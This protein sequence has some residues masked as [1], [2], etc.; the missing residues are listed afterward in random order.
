MY[1][2]PE[3]TLHF[4]T[5]INLLLKQDNLKLSPT[6]HLKK[7]LKCEKIW[8]ELTLGLR[9]V[10]VTVSTS[11]RSAA[12]SKE[13]TL[14]CVKETSEQ[15]LSSRIAKPNPNYYSTET[16]TATFHYS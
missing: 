2:F 8:P 7:K 15:P 3:K 5:N 14:F 6:F 12:S 11:Y 13:L 1:C 16:E 9:A 10:T 4:S